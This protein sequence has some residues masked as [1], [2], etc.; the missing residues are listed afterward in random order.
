M[1]FSTVPNNEYTNSRNKNKENNTMSPKE[2]NIS[3]VDNEGVE[4][5]EIPE[6]EFKNWW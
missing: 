5:K 2:H 3:I 6:M 4:I 1:S